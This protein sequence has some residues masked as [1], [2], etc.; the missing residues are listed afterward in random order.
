MKWDNNYKTIL[1]LTH[2]ECSKMVVVE[3]VIIMV[4]KLQHT[5][6]SLLLCAAFPCHFSHFIQSLT[7]EGTCSGKHQRVMSHILNSALKKDTW[8]CQI[9]SRS[10]PARLAIRVWTEPQERQKDTFGWKLVIDSSSQTV[11]CHLGELSFRAVAGSPSLHGSV[12]AARSRYCSTAHTRLKPSVTGRRNRVTIRKIGRL[13]KQTLQTGSHFKLCL[14]FFLTWYQE[15]KFQVL[16]FH[17]LSFRLP[18]AT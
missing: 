4:I 2:C 13:N 10:V 8:A 6:F 9:I 11:S 14:L 12:M 1:S 16:Q 5:F 18:K 3:T 17:F 7:S 15:A